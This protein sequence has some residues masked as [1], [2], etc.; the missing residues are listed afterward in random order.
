MQNVATGSPAF[1]AGLRPGDCIIEVNGEDM[2]YATGDEV[3]HAIMQTNTKRAHLLVEFVDGAKRLELKK[4]AVEAQCQ[5]VQ[6]QRQLRALLASGQCQTSCQIKQPRRGL[7]K[8][9]AELD[10]WVRYSL[11][12]AINPT[13]PHPFPYNSLLNSL[14][15][16]Y[17]GDVLNLVT[18]VL[19][20]PISSRGS[21]Q[22]S[23]NAVSRFLRSAGDKVVNELSLAKQCSLGENIVTTGGERLC[24]KVLYHCVF[25]NLEEHLI[26]CCSSAL[27]TARTNGH[28]L[29]SFW[30][31]GFIGVGVSPQLVLE[32]I[33][34]W[35]ENETNRK[36]LQRIG[37][38][39][40]PFPTL[41]EMVERYFPLDTETIV[42]LPQSKLLGGSDSVLQ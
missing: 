29:V 3:V 34:S 6:K 32:T 42:A 41:L 39:F 4:Q 1:V 20:I 27:S 11:R 8:S 14:I 22:I 16:V 23:E 25:G 19:V 38:C 21:S 28:K 18:D 37:L 13:D 2:K 33:R 12:P 5:L 30:L 10:P 24:A 17:S 7:L 35:L 26:S 9:V 36:G 40:H 15:V 31:E